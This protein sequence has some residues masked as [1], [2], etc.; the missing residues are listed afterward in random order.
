ME[1]ESHLG[2]LKFNA[3]E[4]RERFKWMVIPKSCFL[5]GDN[6]PSTHADI[7]SL[8]KYCHYNDQLLHVKAQPDTTKSNPLVFISVFGLSC[9]S[10][11]REA[12]RFSL[13]N[14]NKLYTRSVVQ[15]KMTRW[16][17]GGLSTVCL[18]SKSYCERWPFC[19]SEKPQSFSCMLVMFEPR[20]DLGSRLNK[21]GNLFLQ[22]KYKKYYIFLHNSTKV[23]QHVKVLKRKNVDNIQMNIQQAV[24]LKIIF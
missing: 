18:I 24:K 17:T 1:L 15:P 13:W 12:L 5:I 10:Y 20:C 4:Q 8:N 9:V 16:F 6:A 14:I 19:T 23:V 22:I 2:N 21:N 11:I 7:S 3:K